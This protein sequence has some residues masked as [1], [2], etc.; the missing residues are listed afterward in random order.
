MNKVLNLKTIRYAGWFFAVCV[1][2]LSMV[3]TT[4]VPAYGSVAAGSGT[5]N[6][7]AK[8]AIVVTPRR[9]T[10]QVSLASNPSTGYAWKVTQMNKRLV[11]LLKTTTAA[12]RTGLIGA[13]GQQIFWF[14]ATPQ[15]FKQAVG[16]TSI[17]FAYAR[18]W[19]KQ[20]AAE[21]KVVKVAF[22][23]K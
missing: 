4:I 21:T 13:P 8:G 20:P 23:R 3:Q 19:E 14:R 22:L 5:L 6:S 10:F 2:V 15:A 18:P 1:P 12:S 17:A 7:A 16:A 9:P 11:T